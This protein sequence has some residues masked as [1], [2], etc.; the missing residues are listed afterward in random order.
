MKP[1]WIEDEGL[2]RENGVLSLKKKKV[3]RE[4]YIIQERVRGEST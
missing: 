4:V 2:E 3:S 1:Y